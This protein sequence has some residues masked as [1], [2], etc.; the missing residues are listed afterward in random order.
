MRHDSESLLENA[1]QAI[2]AAEPDAT[3]ISASARRV[4]DRLGI[5]SANALNFAT[6][7]SCADVQRLLPSYRAGTLSSSRS[8]LLKAHLRD[9]G[10]CHRASIDGS[11]GVALDWS[12]PQPARTLSWNLR[13]FRW[14]LAPTLA[15]LALTFFLY[16]SFWQVPP[17]VR[18]EVESI[19]G[20]AYRIS[21]AGDLPLSTGDKLNEGDHLRTGG[22]AHAVL[23]LSDGSTVEVNERSVLAVNARGRNMTVAVDNGAVIVQAAKRT[24]GHLYVNTP[25]CRVAVTGT[26]F[27]VNAGIKG[28]RVAVLEG[29][30][31]VTHAGLETSMH[32]GDQVSTNDNLS[33]EPVEQ[34]IAWSHDLGK[35]LPLLAQFST[36]Q[37]RIDQIPEPQLRYKSDLLTRVPANTLLYVSIPNLGSFLSEA[38]NI[39]HD[40]LKQSPALQQWWEGG[41]HHNTAELDALVEKL[42]QVSEYLGDEVVV[43]GVQQPNHPGF[44][45]LADV[46]KAGLGDVLKQ[47]LPLAGTASGFV[48]FDEASL[49]NA[50]AS[51]QSHSGQ[52]ALIRQH[53]AVFSNS[54]DMLKQM[55]AQLNANASGFATGDFGQQ[56]GAAY[57]RGAGVILA[58]D[59][60][61][62]LHIPAD[63]DS[64]NQ[65]AHKAFQNSGFDGVRYLIAEHREK[66]S[67]PENHVSLQFAGTRQGAASWLAAPAP[68]GSL[69]FVSPNAAI[70]LAFLSKDPAAIA[71]DI[72]KM[73]SPNGTS[74]DSAWNEAQTKLQIDIRND[75]AANLGGDFLL[76]LDGAVL[77]TPAWKAVIEVRN[78]AQLEKTLERLAEDIRNQSGASHPHNIVI[79]SNQFDNQTFYAIHDVTSGAT[80]AQYTFADGYMIVSPVRAL[81]MQALRTHASG[82][83]LAH[84]AAFKALLPTDENAN[85]SAIAYQNIGPVLTPLLSQFSGDAS[86]A[87]SQ[88]A[89]DGRPTAICAWGKDNRIEAASNSHLFGF[90]LLALEAIIHPDKNGNKQP[91]ASVSE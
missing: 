7:G 20:S 69:D 24:S 47:Q 71:D 16:R 2:H 80:V 19:D 17:G 14:A 82:N 50:P 76:S 6:I 29:T 59:L 62:R 70:A 58:A 21:D 37:N 25:D 8:L 77:P 64:T 56:I 55:N 88:L 39:F 67:L 87:L 26:V 51:P 61:Q 60:H 15:A 32:P 41:S 84:S 1:I 72:V 34:Q 86:Q 75:L 10:E 28:S 74:N 30:V 79:Q 83:S 23:R 9:C 11:R 40:Q 73:A 18:A 53:E 12:V 4:A 13:S 85:Y 42:R 65:S 31:H 46:Q 35:Y 5:D 66:N 78:A 81:L 44:A 27:S 49:A 57:S 3:Q 48:V 43:V 22:G 54:V 91:P 90:D 38:N 68:I 89:A 36:L 63:A 45:I 52:Y 33:P